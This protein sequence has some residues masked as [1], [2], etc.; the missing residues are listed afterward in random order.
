[1]TRRLYISE[2]LFSAVFQEIKDAGDKLLQKTTE[3]PASAS[4][5]GRESNRENVASA[6]KKEQDS[7]TADDIESKELRNSNLEAKVTKE[8]IEVE[9]TPDSKDQPN[10]RDTDKEEFN[11]ETRRQ[12]TSTSPTTDGS[13]KASENNEEQPSTKIP[14]TEQAMSGDGGAKDESEPAVE[15]KQEKIEAHVVSI[16]EKEKDKDV[17]SAESTGREPELAATIKEGKK[18]ETTAV[19]ETERSSD[20]VTPTSQKTADETSVKGINLF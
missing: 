18:D 19:T 5:E 15:S 6:G 12:M 17:K 1:M 8:K 10:V 3:N 13:T 2:D 14:T 20:A 4:T 16:E 7:A 11:E 9:K